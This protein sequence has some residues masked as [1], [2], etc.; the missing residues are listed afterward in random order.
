MGKDIP[1]LFNGN[2]DSKACALCMIN[3][4]GKFSII[5]WIQHVNIMKIVRI[6]CICRKA[7]G[8]F[9]AQQKLLA[10]SLDSAV[11]FSPQTSHNLYCLVPSQ[12]TALAEPCHCLAEKRVHSLCNSCSKRGL[13]Y[14]ASNNYSRVN[15][16]SLACVNKQCVN[17][18]LLVQN[19]SLFRLFEILCLKSFSSSFS[20]FFFKQYCFFMLGASFSPS[21]LS[22]ELAEMR[23]V[24]VHL[25]KWR[26]RSKYTS[27]AVE[28]KA[29][30][31]F[32]H[33]VL[34]CPPYSVE[35]QEALAASITAFLLTG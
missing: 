6:N 14:Y 19:L 35:R 31:L 24:L 2:A 5:Q 9:S 18:S 30:L 8:F 4:A 20:F 3:L 12:M 15:S 25:I 23:S 27:L 17:W 22:L 13:D 32:K 34:I 1:K 16:Q 28:I 11:C 10:A 33:Y 29:Y 21:L 26:L 7:L